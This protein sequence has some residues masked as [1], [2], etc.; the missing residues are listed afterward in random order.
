M[1][2][3]ARALPVSV[4]AATAVACGAQAQAPA[5]PPKLTIAAPSPGTV[6]QRGEEVPFHL[7]VAGPGEHVFSLSRVGADGSIGTKTAAGGV[8]ITFTVPANANPGER[9]SL[10]ATARHA[11]TNLIGRQETHI[12][13]G[14]LPGGRPSP[15]PIAGGEAWEGTWVGRAAGSIYDDE[16]RVAFTFSIGTDRS[17]HG[18]GTATLTTR[19]VPAGECTYRHA[20]TPATFA[21][22]IAGR[23]EL[24]GFALQIKG[25]GM[26]GSRIITAI[27]AGGGGAGPAAQYDAFGTA[28]IHPPGLSPR[29]PAIDGGT[30]T[31]ET[32]AATF[33][34][35]YTTTIRRRGASTAP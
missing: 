29:V 3:F 32:E 21:V 35:K 17:V 1:T 4:I 11:T 14:G 24:D 7:K 9:I 2:A 15:S 5:G 33:K 20:Q 13:V 23:R 26:V 19:T 18:K 25:P 31:V 22:T 6:V 10:A 30:K 12:I 16:A 8:T 27:C 28:G 34:V